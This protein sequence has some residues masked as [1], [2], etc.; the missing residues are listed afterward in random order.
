[1]TK[2]LLCII[3]TIGMTNMPVITL[4]QDIKSDTSMNHKILGLRTC[5]YMVP[6]LAAATQWYTKAFGIEPY[7]NEPFYVGF[8]IGGYELGLM[9]SEE[10]PV[11]AANILT[12][13]GVNDIQAVYDSFLQ[14]GAEVHEE[15][16]N[17]GGPLMVASVRD[18]WGNVIGFIY[19][20]V[21]KLE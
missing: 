3:F 21:F 19:N 4:S 18:P 12:Y 15:P 20:P 2:I 9:P 5:A 13:W 7:F 10:K 14:L 6:D 1:M 11:E 16:T 17:V 8:N